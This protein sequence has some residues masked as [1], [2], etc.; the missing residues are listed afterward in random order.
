VVVE[1]VLMALYQ[2]QMDFLEAP[3]VVDLEQVWVALGIRL[4][5]A[6]L[7]A[8]LGEMELA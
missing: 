2:M 5:E 6:H 4:I 3:V 7:K 1:V 8:T